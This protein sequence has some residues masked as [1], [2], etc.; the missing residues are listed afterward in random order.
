MP[1]DLGAYLARIGLDRIR[2]GIAGLAAMQQAQLRAVTFENFDPLLGRVP[3]LGVENIFAKVVERGRGG[4]CFE[5][6]SLFKAALE[7]AGFAPRR[8][9]ARVRMRGGE[10]APRSHLILR[11]EADG[12][13][14]LADAGFGGPGSL[15]PLDLAV[16]EPQQAPNGT[17]RFIDTPASGEVVLERLDGG[18]WLQL[19]GFDTAY[20]TDGEVAA[21]HHLCATWS[22]APFS[23][24]LLLNAYR[25]DTR[26]GLFDRMLTVER[27]DGSETCEIAGFEE[28][29]ELI[30]R[31]GPKL[32]IDDLVAAWERLA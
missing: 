24:H 31:V 12:Q 2:P 17:Y 4:Y 9:L 21:A 28:F 7:A 5:L 18:E 29:A 14:S 8:M 1:F 20:V 16:R 11:V 23:S 32:D 22:D 13:E 30:G 3:L 27:T 6:N 25:G 10:Q 19:Y 15:V 26:Y